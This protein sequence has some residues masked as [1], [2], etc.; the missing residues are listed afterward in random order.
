MARAA[1]SIHGVVTVRKRTRRDGSVYPHWY[2]DFRTPT[3]WKRNVRTDVS[4]ARPEAEAIVDA[5]RLQ[6]EH[7][8]P[9]KRATR[10]VTMLDALV[11][12]HAHDAER[13]ERGELA[14][15][16]LDAY[17]HIAGRVR[18]YFGDE[19]LLH[20]LDRHKVRAFEADRMR[21]V[22]RHTVTKERNYLRALVKLGRYQGWCSLAIEE[23]F[24]AGWR[25]GY[26]PRTRWLTEA[27]ADALIGKLAPKRAAHVAYIL[28]T[29]ADWTPSTTAKASHFAWERGRRGV[30][31]V[32]DTKT[33]FRRR[34]V[35]VL[36]FTERFARL[37]FDYLEEHGRFAPWS[38][39]SNIRDLKAACKRAGIDPCSFKDLRRTVGMWLHMRGGHAGLTALFLGHSGTEMVMRTYARLQGEQLG[40]AIEGPESVGTSLE[41]A[42]NTEADEDH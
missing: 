19:M 13:V 17:E 20:E 32:P 7:L 4:N 29:A 27:D 8:D 18:A 2:C 33:E 25:V 40:E 3:G 11:F 6:E 16:T 41:Q 38:N 39:G 5:R 10:E 42:W 24:S 30:I 28:A 21:L 23:L 31:F 26:K 34:E 1:R 35:P 12:K 37:A 9:R 22:A 36:S 14:A 15:A